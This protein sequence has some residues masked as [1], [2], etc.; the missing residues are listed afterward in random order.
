MNSSFQAFDIHTPIRIYR[1]NLPHWRQDGCTYFVTFRLVDSVPR[2][3]VL[4]WQEARRLWL[5]AHGIPACAPEGEVAHLYLAIS[6]EERRTFERGQA[7]ELH[8]ELDRCHGT[9]I[10]R[11]QENRALVETALLH[12]HDTRYA[13]GDFVIMPNHVHWLVQPMADHALEGILY[14]IK[15]FTAGRLAGTTGGVAW[16]GDSYDRIVRDRRELTAFRR[17]IVENPAKANVPGSECTVYRADW[18]DEPSS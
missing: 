13:C 4:R 1:R 2:S 17:Y 12:F 15:R 7:H 3:V 14:A 9:C 10:L 11:S 18:L 6:A 8:M 16:Q 5:D